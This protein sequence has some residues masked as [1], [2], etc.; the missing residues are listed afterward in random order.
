MKAL[1]NLS[2]RPELFEYRV[3]AGL[4]AQRDQAILKLSD[5]HGG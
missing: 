1:E 3:D 5:E 2:S 4:T